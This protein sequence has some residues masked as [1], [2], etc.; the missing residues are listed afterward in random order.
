MRLTETKSVFKSQAKKHDRAFAGLTDRAFAGL[1]LKGDCT[2]PKHVTYLVVCQLL[3]LGN[4][5]GTAD[6]TLGAGEETLVLLDHVLHCR[7]K[8]M[9]VD[10][11]DSTVPA[12]SQAPSN[13]QSILWP[14]RAMTQLP[15]NHLHYYLFYM[16]PCSRVMCYYMRRGCPILP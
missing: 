4:Q 8:V 2:A 15:A 12:G 10:K 7:G 16:G 1:T 3:R 14:H 9:Q 5:H 6:F 13:S 11:G